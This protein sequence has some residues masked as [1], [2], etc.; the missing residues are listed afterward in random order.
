MIDGTVPNAVE[1]L[2]I[3]DAQYTIGNSPTI[4]LTLRD[5]HAAYHVKL[6]LIEILE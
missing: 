2:L 4:V 5:E 3:Q 1:G 6:P